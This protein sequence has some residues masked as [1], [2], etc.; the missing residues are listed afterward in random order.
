MVETGAAIVTGGA[1]GIGK[2][3]VRRLLESGLSVF[4]IDADQK[5]LDALISESPPAV[6]RVDG[7]CADVTDEQQVM[8]AGNRAAER[9]SSIFALVQIPGG[10]GSERA[11]PIRDFP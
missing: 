5:S 7:C 10:P 6:S 2:A 11:P 9:F 8:A 1:G 4:V 3:T